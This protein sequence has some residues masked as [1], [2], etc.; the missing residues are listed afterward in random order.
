MPSVQANLHAE[1]LRH[2]ER[3]WSEAA[4]R[5]H[6]FRRWDRVLDL[7]HEPLPRWFI[8]GEVNTCYNALD[9]HVGSGRAEQ[10]ALIYDS[11]V[12]GTTRK[13]SYG[14]LLEQTARFAGALRAEGVEKGDRVVLYMPMIPETVIAMLACAR[15][16]AIHSTVFG[17]FGAPEL[18]T[19]I[20]DTAPKVVVTATGGLEGA[21]VVPYLPLLA[22][23]LSLASARVDRCIVYQRP[24]IPADLKAGRELPDGKTGSVAIRL[25]LPPGTL[26]T[27]WNNDEGCV[28]SYLEAFPGYYSTADAGFRDEDGYLWIMSRTDDIINVAGHRLSTGAIEEVLSSHPDLAESAVIGVRCP[29]KGEIPLGLAVLKAGVDRPEDVLVAELVQRVRSEIGPVASFKIAAVVPQLPK[30]RSG[31]ILRGTMKRIADG[32]PYRLPATIDDPATLT[33]VAKV[34]AALG[35]TQK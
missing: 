2:P 26:A 33:E 22:A 6:W 13:Y 17:G 31:K 35:Y 30:T 16:G 14:E 27:L 1:S 21:R 29:I 25:P 3:F 12:T 9:L 7:D 23:A 34:L 11:P 4:E 28:R 10:A 15:I 24:E 32:E 20:D 5:V 18:A 19:R 8:G